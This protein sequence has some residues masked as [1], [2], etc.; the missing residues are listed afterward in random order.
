MHTY[1]HPRLCFAETQIRTQRHPFRFKAGLYN[2]LY[3]FILPLFS[4]PSRYHPSIL[5]LSLLSINDFSLK[6]FQGGVASRV[7]CI[8][9]FSPNRPQSFSRVWIMPCTC[10]YHPPFSTVVKR[11][12]FDILSLAHSLGSFHVAN[13]KPWIIMEK[14]EMDFIWGEKCIWF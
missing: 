6:K 7:P 8:N 11:C 12:L 9:L 10:K 4:W 14:I 3:T 13:N 1:F 2:L 5:L